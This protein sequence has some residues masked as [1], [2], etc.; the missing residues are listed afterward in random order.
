[1]WPTI[2]YSAT[3]V[4]GTKEP[5]LNGNPANNHAKRLECAELAPAF[6]RG[7]GESAG[8]P[9]RTPD[10]SRATGPARGCELASYTGLRW[11]RD[12]RREEVLAT[13]FALFDSLA[14]K[15]ERLF[16]INP[17]STIEAVNALKK[18]LLEFAKRGDRCPLKEILK[19]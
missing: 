14:Q 12:F 13:T 6:W 16:S 11:R 5:V 1:L 17:T 4:N 15:A 3:L 7:G 9:E 10:A 18:F 2:A 8:K 19:L